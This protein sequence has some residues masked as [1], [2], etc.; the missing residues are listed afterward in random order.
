MGR[1]VMASQQ[2]QFRFVTW[3]VEFIETD[4]LP[5]GFHVRL[6]FTRGGNNEPPIGGG[7]GYG[8]APQ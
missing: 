7:G 4:A 8:Y 5:P 3:V 6:Y 1:Y 2:T